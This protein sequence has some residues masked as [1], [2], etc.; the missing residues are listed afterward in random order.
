MQN[1]K[2]SLEAAQSAHRAGRLDDAARGY[3]SF[4]SFYPKNATA[5]YLIG[6]VEIQRGNPSAAL[7]PISRCIE[8][9]PKNLEARAA[10]AV[11]LSSLGRNDE[12]LSALRAAVKV[13]PKH[14]LS[15]Y[16]IGALLLLM[17]DPAGAEKALRTAISLEPRNAM[18]FN[19]LGVSLRRQ[20][21]P[22]AELIP[23]FERALELAPQMTGPLL[24]L[25]NVSR[26]SGDPA[27]I[28][29]L[30]PL[31]RAPGA[32]LL[33]G[34]A[35]PPIPSSTA[36]IDEARARFENCLDEAI[37]EPGR[38]SDPLLEIGQSLQ[39]YLAYHGRDDRPLQ[40]KLARA[41]KAACPDLEFLAPHCRDGRWKPEKKL[42]I[43]FLSAHLRAHTIGKLQRGTIRGLP[44]DR[45]EVFVISPSKPSDDI[46]REI[47]S[48]ADKYIVVPENLALARHMLAELKLDILFYPD[49][50][51]EPFTYFLA[52]ARLA[53]L[54]VTTWGHP[55]TPATGAVDWF[56]SAR[57]IEPED[58]SSHYQER[59]ALLSNP[60]VDFARPEPAKRVEKSYFGIPDK[61]RIYLCP[62]TLF[63]FH[64]DFDEIIIDILRNDPNGILVALEGKFTWHDKLRERIC[65]N[66]PDVAQQ[67]HFL[68]RMPEDDFIALCRIADVVLDIP[69]FS[70][71]NTTFEALSAGAPIVHLPGKFMRGRLTGGLL[72]RA[73]LDWGIAKD[74]SEYVAKAL[75][76]ASDPLNWRQ[77]IL[78]NS[79]ILF[80]NSASV[81]ELADFLQRAIDELR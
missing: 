79:G 80:G 5:L 56:V 8:L 72:K 20:E 38:I 16:N 23:V 65:L 33:A 4:L 36:E 58:G 44:R 81:S 21:R 45:F 52:H 12:S 6:V 35:L 14:A 30:R 59:L 28:G 75:E 68:K 61:C 51:M 55:V 39:F 63:K 11:A 40:V 26:E 18:F 37:S 42:R 77:N 43:G 25:L 47:Q 46:A 50:G 13:N 19:E 24:N 60:S 31:C 66:A 17:G 73:G 3:K 22:V 9:E 71:G 15:W 67:I 32:R 70:G 48:A 29:R 34:T 1:F 49:I 78:Q 57:G 74:P 2:M 7:S 62:Q 27:L 69:S 41:V 76:I 53:P 10:L 64:P 54:Q